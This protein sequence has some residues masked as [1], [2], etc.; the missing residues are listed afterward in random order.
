MVREFVDSHTCSS[1]VLM[2][3]HRQANSE[4]VSECIMHKLTNMK[5]VYTPGDIVEDMMTEFNVSIS[6]HK[7]WRSKERALVKARGNPHDYSI[8]PSWLY[9]LKKTNPGKKFTNI[10]LFI[11]NACFNSAYAVL[12]CFNICCVVLF[13][14][15]WKNLNLVEIVSHVW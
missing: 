10:L 15:C 12:C 7:A 9:M 11:K 5:R 8:I 4:F 1:N 6:Y 13:N 14:I 2:V 3:D